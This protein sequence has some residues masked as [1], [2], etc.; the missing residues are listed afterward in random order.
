ML[1]SQPVP[2]FYNSAVPNIILTSLA[3][4]A[5]LPLLLVKG[6]L[7]NNQSYLLL[8]NPVPLCLLSFKMKGTW[9]LE[10][11]RQIMGNWGKKNSSWVFRRR[12]LFVKVKTA[13]KNENCYG[14]KSTLEVCYNWLASWLSMFQWFVTLRWKQ[15]RNVSSVD[16]ATLCI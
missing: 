13:F 16:A 10:V 9:S 8:L 2:L 12:L 4:T 6:K 15:K 11:K 5:Y 1:I 14:S 3:S 7:Q